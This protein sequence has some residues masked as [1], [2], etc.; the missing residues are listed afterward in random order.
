MKVLFLHPNFPGQFK[1]IAKRIADAGHDTKFLCQTHYGR[2]LNGVNR[3][4]L[5]NKSGHEYLEKNCK[6]IND[7]AQMLGIQYRSAFVE[8]KKA[9]WEPDIVISHSGWGCGLYVKEIWPSSRLISYLEWWFNP[10]SEFFSYDE[11][12]KSLNINKSSIKK[13]W[14]R[15]QQIALELSVSDNIVSPTNW[16]KNQLPP[17]FREKC[18]VVFDGIELEKFNSSL[19]IPDKSKFTITYGTRGMDPM[20]CFPQLIE[21]IPGLLQ[22]HPYVNVEIAGEDA[23]YYGN[24]PEKPHRSWGDWANHYLDKNNALDR[25]TFLGKMP[26]KKYQNWL[27]KSRCHVY[28]SHPFVASWSLVE[29]YCSGIPLIVSDI[30]ATKDICETGTGITFTDH[31]HK[32]YLC[33]ALSKHINQTRFEP[34][35]SRNAGR[36]GIEAS[37]AGWGVSGLELTTND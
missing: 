1:H 16:Q 34:I 32:G 23:V 2:K 3:V 29:A 10:T 20:R 21:E 4:T 7:R 22:Q 35:G 31:R 33:E 28:L 9:L 18:R 15:N 17:I 6:N 11:S 24:P 19:R 26:P 30:Q 37:V 36:F 12:N 27:L 8:L 14:Q 25:V 5:K 13:S